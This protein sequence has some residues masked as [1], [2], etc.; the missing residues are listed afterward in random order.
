MA[1]S[2]ALEPVY[3]LSNGKTFLSTAGNH[4]YCAIPTNILSL[5]RH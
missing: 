2:L 1:I 4:E 5:D 3:G